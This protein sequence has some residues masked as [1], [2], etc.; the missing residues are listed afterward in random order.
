MVT[1]AKMQ[2]S[3]PKITKAKR[4]GGMTQVVEHLPSKHKAPS[5]N[6][7]TTKRKRQSVVQVCYVPSNS[8]I[9]RKKKKECHVSFF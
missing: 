9:K 7:S 6:P 2:D 4:A 8:L 1:Q 3:I 5:S